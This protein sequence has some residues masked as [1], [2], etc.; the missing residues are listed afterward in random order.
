MAALYL[1]RGHKERRKGESSQSRRAQG[2][3]DTL[4]ARSRQATLAGVVGLDERYL[5]LQ[6]NPQAR[7][8]LFCFPHAGGGAGAFRAW[9]SR[10]APRVD[11]CPIQLPGRENRLRERAFTTITPLIEKLA[12]VLQPYLDVPFAL[13]GHSMGGLVSFELSRQLRRDHRPGP[14]HLLVACIRAPQRP[15]SPPISQL[16]DDAFL[17]AMSDRY[18]GMPTAVLR[19]AELL[20]LYLPVLRAD[21]TLLD[22]YT[23][24]PAEPLACPISAFGGMQDRAFSQEDLAAWREQT[25]GTFKVRMLPGS[26]FLINEDPGLLLQAL[27]ADLECILKPW[28]HTGETPVPHGF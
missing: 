22:N 21:F 11:V 19:S 24:V 18:G 10:L 6:P 20:E 5:P 7:L 28:H 27:S 16:P 4:A 26:H 2:R 1:V 25:R 8:R 23:Y 3:R 13:F 17:Q 14:F 9:P 15:K 12:D